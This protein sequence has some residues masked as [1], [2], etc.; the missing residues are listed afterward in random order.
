MLTNFIRYLIILFISSIIGLIILD[1]IV[2]TYYVNTNKEIYIPDVRGMYK[3]NAIKKLQS[4]DLKVKIE[5]IPYTKDNEV[6]KV[7]KMSPPSPLKIKTGRMIELS[8]PSERK[9]IVV[10]NLINQSLRNTIITIKNSSLEIDTIMYEHFNEYD[11][12][13]ITFHS[14]KSGQIVESGSKITLM[15][16]KGPPPDLFIVPDLIN[17]SLNRAEKMIIKS[18]LRIGKIDYEYHPGL[19]RKTVVDQSLTPGMSIGI[20]A[21]ID[22]IIS[23]DD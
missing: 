3:N 21:E 5:N 13:V 12:D 9:N 19:L 18:G 23:S 1:N 10:P 22:L 11:K 17:L 6:G 15:V 2:L 8:I 4:L 16:S 14:P 7:L 20:P